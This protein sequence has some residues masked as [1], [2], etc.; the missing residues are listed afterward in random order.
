[1]TEE[2]GPLDMLSWQPCGSSDHDELKWQSAFQQYTHCASNMKSDHIA[3]HLSSNMLFE[4]GRSS[5]INIYDEGPWYCHFR[6]QIPH[7]SM[8]DIND[9]EATL[10]V[11]VL[12]QETLLK[13]SL[14]HSILGRIF[15]ARRYI[16]YPCDPLRLRS[17]RPC[18]SHF[19]SSNSRCDQDICTRRRAKWLWCKCNDNECWTEWKEQFWRWTWR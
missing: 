13:N 2:T 11:T 14:T 7:Q 10:L 15:S 17:F 16:D 3:Q 4:K 12:L 19:R 6:I 9:L 5:I 18:G 8:G 1:M